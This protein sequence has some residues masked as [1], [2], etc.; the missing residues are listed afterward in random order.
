MSIFQQLCCTSDKAIDA[1]FFLVM[2]RVNPGQPHEGL[3]VQ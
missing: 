2:P 1:R 3:K